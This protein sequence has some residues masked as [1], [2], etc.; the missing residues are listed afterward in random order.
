[1]NGCGEQEGPEQHLA[2]EAG[3]QHQHPG[4]HHQQ[5]RGDPQPADPPAPPGAEQG[6]PGGQDH[7]PTTG[8]DHHQLGAGGD[9]GGLLQGLVGV[10]HRLAEADDQLHD[11]GQG[12]AAGGGERPGRDEHAAE[13]RQVPAG[14]P[15]QRD[16]GGDG[17]QQHHRGDLVAGG[18]HGDDQQERDQLVRLERGPADQQPDAGEVE[19]VRHR[20]RREVVLPDP[21]DDEEEEQGEPDEALVAG[22]PAVH[23]PQHHQVHQVEHHRRPGRDPERVGAAGQRG[24][25]GA[26]GEEAG[27]VV[28][29][30]ADADGRVDRAGAQDVVDDADVLVRPRVAQRAVQHRGRAVDE[31]DVGDQVEPQ[32]PLALVAVQAAQEAADQQQQRPHGG[33][34]EQRHQTEAAH[35]SGVGADEA[36]RP[37]QRRQQRHRRPPAL[38]ADGGQPRP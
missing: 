4:Q 12:V 9:G 23:V 6:H 28:V 36:E 18:D 27:P 21:V 22:Q 15:P 1:M 33:P 37:Q 2:A 19:H 38:G 35:G 31:G 3:H 8:P 14:G 25:Q 11:V 10:G 7:H 16:Q 32:H 30:L 26:G 34:G 17:Q 5:D 13:H 29:D 20:L 24:E